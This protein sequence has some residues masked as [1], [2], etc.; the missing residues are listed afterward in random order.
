MYFFYKN[1]RSRSLLRGIKPEEIKNLGSRSG[2]T[3]NFPAIRNPEMNFRA[4]TGRPF[5]TRRCQSE[6]YYYRYRRQRR[7]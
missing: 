2:M 6:L 1:E 7:N 4:V 5:G 3:D